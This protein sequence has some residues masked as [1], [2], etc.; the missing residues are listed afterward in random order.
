[1]GA[2]QGRTG[3]PELTR[4][5]KR[6]GMS[7]EDAAEV[8]GVSS[9]TW[10]RWERGEQGVRA[11]HRRLIAAA[12]G[13]DAAEVERWVDGWTAGGTTPWPFAD[14]GASEPM[15]TVKAAEQLWRLEMDPSRRHLLATLPFVPAALG[16]WLASVAYDAPVRAVAGQG[17]GRSV[18]H[19]DAVRVRAACEGFRQMDMRF[20]AGLVRPVVVRYLNEVVTPLLRGRYDERVGA[21]LMSAA[22]AMTGMA[23][24]TA[25][26]MGNHG[27]AQ[28]HFGV[29]LSLAKAGD[30]PLTAAWVLTEMTQ[31]ALHIDQA[32]W[33]VRLAG[34]AVDS[35]REAQA[36]P[37]VMA[38]LTLRQAWATAAQAKPVRSG[39]RHSAH[40]VEHLIAETE[41]S[42]AQGATDR[43]PEW[44]AL[45]DLPELGAEMGRC[46]ALLGEHQRAL[47]CAETAVAAFEGKF[48]R[49]AQFNR[50]HAAESYLGLGELDQAL[51]T[52]RPAVP[53]ARSLSSTRAVEFVERFTAQLE[54]HRDVIAV[55]EFREHVRTELAA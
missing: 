46:W 24:W 16:E 13:A 50:M 22:A 6:R 43:D 10:A 9:T 34:A 54:P 21:E 45:H 23:G 31:Q 51:H 33:A 38:L 11:R 42:Y 32:R 36:P 17:L 44:V 14:C 37:R 35:A 52:A 4:E 29:A 55:R 53:T 40:Q 30:D 18:G 49:S 25:F 2:P 1:M 19:A 26:D 5:R 3:R 39:D 48:A 15:A 47:R 28:R 27:Q 41:R 8:V 12:F 7:Q 20:G